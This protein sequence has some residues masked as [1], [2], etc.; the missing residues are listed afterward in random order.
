M[1]KF[2]NEW[3]NCMFLQKPL[4]FICFVL[5]CFVFFCV[6]FY[7]YYYFFI[8]LFCFVFSSMLV[9]VQIPLLVPDL[10]VS[11]RLSP[12][13]WQGFV[14]ISSNDLSN[15]RTVLW[16]L[17]TKDRALYL[18]NIM[19]RKILASPSLSVFPMSC[20]KFHTALVCSYK[21]LLS[22]YCVIN[23]F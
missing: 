6:I 15:W 1:N 5:F 22:F 3:H 11:A 23:I 13:E 17:Q 19:G 21:T 2:H 18:R 10:L 12:Y 14:E 20:L 9:L 7:Y 8:Y 4:L 16:N